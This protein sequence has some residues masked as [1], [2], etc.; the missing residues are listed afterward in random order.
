[1]V[2]QYYEEQAYYVALLMQHEVVAQDLSNEQLGQSSPFHEDYWDSHLDE[3]ANERCGK[4]RHGFQGCYLATR[5]DSNDFLEEDLNQVATMKSAGMLTMHT[6]EFTPVRRFFN[7]ELYGNIF[8]K[9]TSPISAAKSPGIWTIDT[10]ETTPV[11]QLPNKETYD[12]LLDETLNCDAAVQS[13]RALTSDTVEITPVQQR[14]NEEIHNLAGAKDAFANRR[15]AHATGTPT[16][17]TNTNEGCENRLG[18][19]LGPQDYFAELHNYITVQIDENNTDYFLVETYARKIDVPVLCSRLTDHRQ[20]QGDASDDEPPQEHVRD[21]HLQ[22]ADDPML[23]IDGWEELRLL[24][25]ERQANAEA[26]LNLVMYGLFQASIGT[27]YA[28]A[29]PSIEAIRHSVMQAWP[30]Y[31]RPGNTGYLHLVRPQS[32]TLGT[33]MQF[34]VEFSNRFFALPVADVPT[35]RR[36]TWEGVWSEAEPVAAYHTQGASTF[37]L[38][39]QSGLMEWCGPDLRT[40]CNVHVERQIAPPLLPVQLQRGTLLEVYIHFGAIEE[41]YVAL[42]QTRVRAISPTYGCSADED[43]R[44]TSLQNWQPTNQR[45]RPRKHAAN[46]AGTSSANHPSQQPSSGSDQSYTDSSDGQGD[47][48][49]PGSEDSSGSDYDPGRYGWD[50]ELP[51]GLVKVACFKRGP[52]HN[53]DP[54]L[55]IVS[56]RNEEDLHDHLA[57]LYRMPAR[58]IKG[59]IF[60]APEPDFAVE[61]AAWPIIVE[62]TQDRHDV[63]T[64]KLVVIQAEF[65]YSR[66][67]AGDIAKQWR[68]VILPHLASRSDVIA[69][70]DALNYCEALA[71]SRCLVWHHSELWK[72]QDPDHIIR[73]GDLIRVAIPPIDED[74]CESTW[75]R[76]QDTYD[77]GRLVGFPPEGSE[78]EYRD[79]TPRSS[80]TGLRSSSISDAPEEGSDMHNQSGPTSLQ[81]SATGGCC[82]DLGSPAGSTQQPN[83]D[84]AS[85]QYALVEEKLQRLLLTQTPGQAVEVVLYGLCHEDVGSF[86]GHLQQLSESSLQ[87]LTDNN[88]PIFAHLSRSY[89]LVCPQPPEATATSL[90]IIV[91]FYEEENTPH[92]A[93]IPT[94]ENLHLWLA[95]GDHDIVRQAVYYDR[96][97]THAQLF[98]GLGDWCE[99]RSTYRCDAW[100]RDQ[101]VQAGSEVELGRGDLLTLRVACCH[102]SWNRATFRTFP[103]ADAFYGIVLEM[104]ANQCIEP[105]LWHLFWQEGNSVHNIGWELQGSPAAAITLC[106]HWYGEFGGVLCGALLPHNRASCPTLQPS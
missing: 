68:V 102:P 70:T 32:Q 79:L 9:P 42:F 72:Q 101:P 45:F 69:A 34:L 54:I 103:N 51:H 31:F 36:V 12:F 33:E 86:T 40:I 82:G 105:V 91:E 11:Q 16:A 47:R 98:R 25:A 46:E 57:T 100:H 49:P 63:A 43:V 30:E 13:T 78:E 96:I 6:V 97:S 5:D 65:Y 76:V 94:L 23:I 84:P 27:R 41:D 61:N 87:D 21:D 50:D 22:E 88:W 95:D 3:M 19:S 104:T 15:I 58:F 64:Q 85:H 59:I 89:L 83:V 77:A 20:R 2:P 66:A 28:T 93:H 39:I 80:V 53:N 14:L 4:Q 75:I 81:Q 29:Q 67:N 55:S 74:M 106:A 90:H 71:D 92:P 17:C 52:M 99:D 7:D 56:M 1:M 18:S 10:V 8:E 26:K 62:Q 37:Q 38:L 44:T 48:S 35:V 73:D 60:V 24:L